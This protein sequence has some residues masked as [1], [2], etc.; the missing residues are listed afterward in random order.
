MNKIRISAVS[1]TNTKPFLYGIQNSAIKDLIELSVDNPSD[2][3]QKLIDDKADIGLIPV[4]A[5]LSLPTWEIISDYCIGANGAVNS[6]F[7]FSNCDIRAV[8]KVQLDPQSRTS[9]NLARVLLK[10]FWKIQPELI[11][12]AADYGTS[13]ENETAFVQIG[14][15]T[16]G[17]ASQYLYV[18]DLSEEWYKYTG[19][20]FVFAAWIANKPVPQ[21]FV[22][23]FN[24]ALNFGLNYR[25]EL[26][27]DLPERN[28]FDLKD[29]LLN[30]L[31]FN[32]TQDKR[33]ALQLF[34][35]QVKAL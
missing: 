22:D 13:N 11:A 16:F 5:T 17:K 9:N 21:A 27:K 35:D 4:A 6:V 15:R 3:A 29:Y 34:L 1:Y 23:Q 12:D 31:D 10:N 7:I 20:P 25:T 32:L 33:V 28:D 18:Y 2:C 14:D 30:K 24:A 8:K 26:L 19:L